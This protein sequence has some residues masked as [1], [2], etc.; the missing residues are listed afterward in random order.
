M[1]FLLL[2]CRMWSDKW[3]WPISSADHSLHITILSTKK[4]GKK[5]DV[6]AKSQKFY[7]LFLSAFGSD[8][9]E[10]ALL[11][12]AVPSTSEKEKFIDQIQKSIY[13]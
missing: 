4:R 3:C 8:T 13:Y 5:K 6:F 7:H 10:P 1:H 9:Q 2:H 12:E 11:F